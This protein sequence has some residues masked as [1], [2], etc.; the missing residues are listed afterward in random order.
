MP[1][2]PKLGQK[3]GQ[4]YT[5]TGNPN[6]VYFG[7]VANVTFQQAKASF[8]EYLKSLNGQRA[9]T[10][11]DTLTV[12]ALCEFFLEWVEKCRSPRTYDE[13][14][15]HLKLFCKHRI[16]T[17]QLAALPAASITAADLQSFLDSLQQVTK[18]EE[19]RGEFTIDKYAT[20]IKA[21]FN[22][23]VKHPSPVS[24]LPSGF[25]PFSSIEKFK[26]PLDPLLE[27][28]LP[29]QPEIAALLQFAD[30]D[31]KPVQEGRRFRI[32]RPEEYRQ[33][34]ENPY[35]GFQ[36]MLKCYLHTGART[37][38][39]AKCRVRDFVR[40]SRLIVLGKHKR[41]ATMK[42]PTTRR[43]MLNDE[44]LS[45]IQEQCVG[46]APDT[47]IFTDP[48]G[49]PWTRLSL[50]KRFAHVRKRAGVR[51]EITIYSFRHLW[52]SEMVMTGVGIATVARM[53]GTSILMIER[54]YGHLTSDH[55]QQA[56]QQLDAFRQKRKL[57]A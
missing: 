40:A 21:A 47:F 17:Q 11:N 30:A 16:G 5:K 37:S 9:A 44:A 14:R 31:L 1:R 53:A 25:R 46:K 4:W 2:Q 32:R 43:I 54:V 36:T 29:T 18:D 24:Y 49:K 42:E 8:A 33:E 13:R 28:D 23:G 3:N 52:I 6:G 27:G 50:D 41:A 26:R 57:S 51:A 20:S 34:F 15:R 45:M 7:P 10:H 22:W 35:R 48:N 19:E 56:Q 12:W 38:E 55:F 39:L